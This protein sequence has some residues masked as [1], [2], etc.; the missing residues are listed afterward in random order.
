MT[1]KRIGLFVRWLLL[2][3][4]PSLVNG[5]TYC[6]PTFSS[7]CGVS[8][9]TYYAIATVKIPGNTITLDNLPSFTGCDG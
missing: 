1:Q 6:T 5:Q 4:V 8:S 7:G 3:L 2:F 9:P